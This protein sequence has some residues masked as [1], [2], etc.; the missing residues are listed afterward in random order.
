MDTIHW[1]G[2]NRFL[3]YGFWVTVLTKDARSPIVIF[4]KK[5]IAGNMGAMATTN[6]GGLIDIN[7]SLAVEAP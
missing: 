2:V 5:R 6:T 7:T 1:A 4:N 3:D